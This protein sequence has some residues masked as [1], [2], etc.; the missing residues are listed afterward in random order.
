M[1]LDRSNYFLEKAK[2]CRQLRP[3]DG[4]LDLMFSIQRAIHPMVDY[5]LSQIQS[6]QQPSVDSMKGSDNQ[7]QLWE[8]QMETQLKTQIHQHW[9]TF[10]KRW[11]DKIVEPDSKEGTITAAEHR[12][13]LSVQNEMENSLEGSH[14]ERG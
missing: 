1:R 5:V 3:L 12:I 13:R 7:M 10:E 6:Q 11:T 2:E 14:G 8:G 4:T 9:D